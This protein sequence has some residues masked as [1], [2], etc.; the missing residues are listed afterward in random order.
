M[1]RNKLYDESAGKLGPKI[2]RDDVERT[3]LTDAEFERLSQHSQAIKVECDCE[4]ANC[5]TCR[6]IGKLMWYAGFKVSDERKYCDFRI[7]K[8]LVDELAALRKKTSVR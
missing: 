6:E 5:M 4:W 2:G 1:K 8:A 3:R 7:L